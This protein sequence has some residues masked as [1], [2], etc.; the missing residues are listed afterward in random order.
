MP[1]AAYFRNVGAALFALLMIVDFCLPRS[2]EVQS[3]DVPPPVIKIISDRKWPELVVL[4]TTKGD[5]AAVAPSPW[6]KDPPAPPTVREVPAG[7]AGT[8]TALALMS[9]QESRHGAP[10]EQKRRQMTSK[11]A[12]RGAR[13]Y[14]PPQMAFTAHQGNY[15]WLG[16]R[17]W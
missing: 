13:K 1:L 7:R 4:D 10:V 2:P 12:T 8:S 15:A 3:T 11:H 14:S 17:Y 16:F 5:T 6:D 9:S